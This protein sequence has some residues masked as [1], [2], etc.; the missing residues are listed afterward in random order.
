M[1][2]EQHNCYLRLKIAYEQSPEFCSPCQLWGPWRTMFWDPV[3]MALWPLHLEFAC[4]LSIPDEMR[5]TRTETQKN[6]MSK[7]IPLGSYLTENQSKLPANESWALSWNP[8]ELWDT[9]HFTREENSELKI[10]VMAAWNHTEII[11][12]KK[13]G[14]TGASH[15]GPVTP[16]PCH[17]K[18]KMYPL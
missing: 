16:I 9:G 14:K 18:K 12:S 11:S 10:R 8:L 13:L 1:R 3:L 6:C 4:G 7:I 2:R 5:V 15:Q 17:T